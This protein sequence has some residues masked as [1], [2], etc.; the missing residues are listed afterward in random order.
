[1]R[2]TEESLS[3]LQGEKIS[4]VLKRE[5]AVRIGPDM[6]SFENIGHRSYTPDSKESL[7]FSAMSAT[8]FQHTHVSQIK[9]DSVINFNGVEAQAE[10]LFKAGYIGKDA[11]G[12][13]IIPSTS[14]NTE[15]KI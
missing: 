12:N 3:E 1:M 4:D 5:G 13:Y 8:G 15:K 9:A 14:Q 11:N 10:S 2:P 6:S 7:G